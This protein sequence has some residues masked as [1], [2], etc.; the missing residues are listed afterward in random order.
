M[1]GL[2]VAA[3]A[4]AAGPAAPECTLANGTVV[5]KTSFTDATIDALG[6]LAGSAAA[7]AVAYAYRDSIAS[8][9]SRPPPLPMI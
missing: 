8:L 2:V 6:T 7:G 5:P 3:A 9:F 4:A 1:L